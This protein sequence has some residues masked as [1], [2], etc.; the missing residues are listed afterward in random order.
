MK[1]ECIEEK[2]AKKHVNVLNITNFKAIPIPVTYA[3][4]FLQQMGRG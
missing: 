4:F 3:I 2:M 1:R